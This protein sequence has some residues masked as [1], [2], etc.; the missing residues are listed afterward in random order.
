MNENTNNKLFVI[1]S[2]TLTDEQISQAK[3]EHAIDQF[4]TLPDDLQ[5]IWSNIPPEAESIGSYVDQFDNWVSNQYLP[6]DIALVQGDFGMIY[7]LTTKLKSKSI[8][9]CY[10]TTKRIATE[11]VTNGELVKKSIFKHI[12][13]RF[14]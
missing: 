5:K 10:A 2:H 7:S 13:F 6:G 9:C 8:P 3:L 12:R 1:M 14:Y 4:V 11:K